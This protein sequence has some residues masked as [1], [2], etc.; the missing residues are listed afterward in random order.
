MAD[1][2]WISVYETTETHKALLLQA[3]L[4]E[5]G[6]ESVLLSKMDSTNIT[7]GEV[8][9]MVSPLQ[10]AEALLLVDTEIL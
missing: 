4:K 6:I 5:N 3:I 9:V 10:A 2:S 1:E 8:C 7:L